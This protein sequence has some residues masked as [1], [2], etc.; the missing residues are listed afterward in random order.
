MKILFKYPTRS[1]PMWFK[2]TLEIYYSMLSNLHS[3]EFILSLNEDDETM[4][5]SEMRD[6]LDSQSHLHYYF[7]K[8][9]DKI[10]AC[11]ADMK[12]LDFDIFFLISD[13]M[14]PIVKNFD[15][16]IVK[17]MKLHFPNLDGALHFDD[18][19][20][21]PNSLHVITLS[22]MGKTLYDRFGYVYNPAYKSFFCDAEFTDEVYQA[23]KVIHLPQIIVKH[24]W[25]G[26][27]KST[28]A[29]YRRN[30]KMGRP[31]KVTYRQRKRDGFPGG[32][33]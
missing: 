9:Q 21:D 12:D 24:E 18:G 31:D 16:I 17:E 23:K 28:D 5:N 1:R 30:S 8:H 6:F 3:Y 15:D 11:N 25:S 19:R 33:R 20:I 32:L 29:L 13:D 22:I 14:I 2:N 26:G 27:P 10:E 4:N 7:G